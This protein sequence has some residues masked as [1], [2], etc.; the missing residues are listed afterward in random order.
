MSTVSSAQEGLTHLRRSL[1][2]E[3]ELSIRDLLA[4]AAAQWTLSPRTWAPEQNWI[5]DE[6]NARP[7]SYAIPSFG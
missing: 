1:H 5:A 3:R 4:A 6:L 2:R 7:I